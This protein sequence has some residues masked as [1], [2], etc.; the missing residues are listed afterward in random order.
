MLIFCTQQLEGSFCG[1]EEGNFLPSNAGSE[2]PDANSADAAG[3]GSSFP[4]AG[5]FGVLS[6]ISTAVQSTVSELGKQA[7]MHLRPLSEASYQ[8][9]FNSGFCEINSERICQPSVDI[10][11]HADN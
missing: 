3:D 10:S 8:E 1:S 11:C 2:N 6:T 9:T 7:N 5:A 4:I